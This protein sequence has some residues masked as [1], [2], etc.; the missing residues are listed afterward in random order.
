[1]KGSSRSAISEDISLKEL[2]EVLQCRAQE[3]ASTDA[4]KMSLE[5]ICDLDRILTSTLTMIRRMLNSRQRS[6]SLPPEIL[7][8]I[9][10]FVPSGA[11]VLDNDLARE[12]SNVN[13]MA[14]VPLTQRSPYK[15]LDLSVQ[16]EIK[17]KF[18]LV[19]K[20]CAA[21]KLMI[22]YHVLQRDAGHRVTQD[23]EMLFECVEYKFFEEAPTMAYPD[24]CKSGWP[25][26]YPPWVKSSQF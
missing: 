18:M 22:E 9:F 20:D 16:Q 14:L 15:K 8:T 6:T 7:S 11:R 5:L 17:E 13:T 23:V 4:S 1:M 12:Q 25:T 19:R 10:Q 26:K 21:I 2:A 24:I 3:A